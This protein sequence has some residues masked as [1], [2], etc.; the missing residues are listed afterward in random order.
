[1]PVTGGESDVV[2]SHTSS[3]LGQA[4]RV[5]G[6]PVGTLSRVAAHLRA[7]EGRAGMVRVDLHCRAAGKMGSSSPCVLV[8][9]QPPEESIGS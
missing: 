3:S 7:L 6:L 5:L 4:E 8:K 2:R 9:I 1:M